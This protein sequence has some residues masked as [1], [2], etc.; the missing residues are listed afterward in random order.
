MKKKFILSIFGLLSLCIFYSC[1]SGSQVKYGDKNNNIP[2]IKHIIYF[3]PQVDPDIEEIKLPTYNAFYSAV[4]N[5]V[6]QTGGYKMIRIDVPMVYDSVDTNG[7]KD[8]CKNNNAQLAVVPKIK[9][10]KVGF[11]KLTFSN[12]VLVHLKL[13]D[14]DGHFIL[15][16]FVDT[17]IGK[18]RLLGASENSVKVGT[19]S[20]IGLM[21]KKLKSL[22]R[23]KTDT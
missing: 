8:Y 10:F 19:R 1:A 15:E 23:N 3:N 11:G 4:S 17:Y 16:A 5:K 14:S 20:A 12:Q 6:H 13:F 22:K 9:Y 21:D 7:I 18:G 2:E